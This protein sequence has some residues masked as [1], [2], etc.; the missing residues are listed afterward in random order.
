MEDRHFNA[1]QNGQPQKLEGT[2]KL[3]VQL[4][5]EISAEELRRLVESMPQRVEAVIGSG[6]GHTM[7]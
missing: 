1:N 5:N 7:Y 2:S 3:L 4:L 6:G